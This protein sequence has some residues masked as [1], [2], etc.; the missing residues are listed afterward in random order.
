MST[1]EIIHLRMLSPEQRKRLL[2]KFHLCLNP[3]GA[4]LFDVYSLR[5]FAES[6]RSTASRSPSTWVMSPVRRT[7]RAERNSPSWLARRRRTYCTNSA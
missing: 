4:V 5:G 3:G 6:S 7:I 1:V 2:D